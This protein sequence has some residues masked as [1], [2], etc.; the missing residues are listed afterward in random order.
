M[1]YYNHPFDGKKVWGIPWPIDTKNVP[2]WFYA[3]SSQKKRL[4][5]REMP[6]TRCQGPVREQNTNDD[7]VN[8]KFSILI[9]ASSF[10]YHILWSRLRSRRSWSRSRFRSSGS[11]SRSHA[12]WSRSRGSW[13]R[14][15][16]RGSWSRYHPCLLITAVTS[17]EVVIP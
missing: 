12:S 15:R 3:T 14:S 5:K 6:S 1:N 10:R 2:T 7:D 11:R 16:S 13:S 17:G 9:V 4:G 8:L